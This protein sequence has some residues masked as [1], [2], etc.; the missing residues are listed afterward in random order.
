MQILLINSLSALL[1]L[2]FAIWRFRLVQSWLDVGAIFAVVLLLLYPVRA[3]VLL[4]FG[5]DAL[6]DY[7]G[8]EMSENIL[9]AS[10]LAASGACGY[11]L[12][13]I[14][15]GKGQAFLLLSRGGQAAETGDLSA[16]KVLLIASS[17]GLVYK[18]ATGDYISYLIGERKN[19]AIDQV[20]NILMSFQWAA[21]IGAWSIFFARTRPFGWQ[22]VFVVTNI[23]VIPYQIVQ[24]SKTFL[25]LTLLGIIIAY[26][27]RRGRLPKTFFLLA[28]FII[29]TYV[30]P[31]VHSFREHVNLKYGGI[32]SVM[33]II[34][35]LSNLDNALGIEPASDYETNA[36][37]AVSARFGGIDHLHGIREIVPEVLDYRYGAPYLSVLTNF[38][39]RALW[40]SKPIYS[41]G[42]DYGASLGTITSV[43]PFPIAEAY[44]DFGTVGVPFGMFLWA[45]VLVALLKL[46][47]QAART[48]QR[49]AILIFF[50]LSQVYW[51]TS[52]ETTA[53]TLL[54]GVP[55]QAL[56]LWILYQLSK[57]LDGKI[58]YSAG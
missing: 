54:S 19:P 38:I 23:I 42:A 16:V 48:A 52:P 8:A 55:Q 21:L 7:P 46:V 13:F 14:L 37:L 32:P 45:F 18:I 34:Q 28:I 11:V 27:W 1:L 22:R 33:D 41:R 56:I 57:S 47:E 36:L 10:L 5:T 31:F 17:F 50:Y 26:V 30:F 3:I 43:T 25:S 20:V 49:P 29:I 15:L 35:D 44:W 40:P 6:P 58:K 9:S 53:A 2:F 12:G 24:G 51:M 4:T 39:P